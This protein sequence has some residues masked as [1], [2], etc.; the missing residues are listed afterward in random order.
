MPKRP[1][2]ARPVIKV[3]ASQKALEEKFMVLF[4][5]CVVDQSLIHPDMFEIHLR[6]RTGSTLKDCGMTHGTA[7]K[8]E[9]VTAGSGGG[10]LI[11]GEVTAL[12]ARCDA[13]GAVVVVRGYDKA[14]R[15]HSGRKTQTFKN[16]K[17]SDVATKLARDA[18]LKIGTVDDSGAVLDVIS[19]HNQSDWEFLVA[20]AEELGFEVLVQEG[21]F[22]FRAPAD[23]SE[24]PPEGDF[25]NNDDPNTLIYGDD[26]L[27]FHPRVSGAQQVGQIEVRSWDP[28][29]KKAVVAQ[30]AA[31]SDH[32]TLT[33]STPSG[34][35]GKFS[36][37]SAK[38][39]H[40]STP[41]RTQA[42]ADKEASALA[43]HVGSSFA[44]AE[45]VCIGTPVVSAGAKVAISHVGHHFTGKYTITAARHTFDNFD[46]YMTHFTISGN[47]DRSM[48]GL[49][50]G[51]TAQQPDF[52]GVVCAQ[53]TDNNDPDT[54]G[55]VKLKFPWLSD[56]Y[57]TD[58]VRMTHPGSG[59]DSGS[60]W[61]PEVNDEVLVAF[62]HGDMRHPYVLG[63]LHNGKDKSPLGDG[64]FDNGKVKRRGMVSRKG[65]KLI[66]FDD[67]SKSG[68]A[69]HSGNGKLKISINEQNGEIKITADKKVT[70]TTSSDKITVQAGGAMDVIAQ[71][72]L[73]LKGNGVDI[74]AGGGSV[75]VTGSSIKLN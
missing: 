57:E 63:A 52:H 35:A 59:P 65:H 60:V 14:H 75:S 53:I 54:K 10:V 13:D 50:S 64:L 31:A 3:G 19:Q 49:M 24:A 21:K 42:Q 23:S 74:D 22:Y 6:D 27:E 15:L 70:I 72:K 32:A 44:E 25:D 18:G 7:V 38:F 66:F 67:S 51:A 5:E 20:H 37:S 46:G 45:G 61:M 26:L 62:E 11:D 56:S 28:E 41:H 55:R 58:W 69:I 9:C 1:Y 48:L 2:F 17:V 39:T 30:S 16:E 68:V 12:E 36:A 47:Q 4:E 34:L 73:T 8:L 29:E 33:G 40:V 43:Q 71:Q